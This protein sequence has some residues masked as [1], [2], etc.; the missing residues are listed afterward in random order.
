MQELEPCTH[1]TLL[2]VMSEK[3]VE[4]LVRHSPSSNPSSTIR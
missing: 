2:E 4:L 1:M 3:H